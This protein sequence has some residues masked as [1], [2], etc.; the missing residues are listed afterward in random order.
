M[1]ILNVEKDKETGKLTSVAET[2]ISPKDVLKGQYVISSYTP[3]NEEKAMR[4]MILQHFAL[5]YTTMY[6]PR[7]EFNDMSV[8][9]RMTV[10]EMAFNTYQPNDG[11][12]AWGDEINAWRSNAMRPI[13]RNK[14]VSIA[15]HATARLIFPKCFAYNE[16]SDEQRDA[17]QVMEDLMEW[18]ADKSNYQQNALYRVI[19]ALTDPASIGYTEYCET[20]R[21]VKR[22]NPDGTYREEVMLDETLSGF[23]NTVVPVDELF[24]ENFY[25]QD[26]QKQGWLVWRRVIGYGLAESKYKNKSGVLSGVRHEHASVRR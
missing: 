2:K 20:Y 14:C 15:A 19:T 17:A 24:I 21:K 25:E 7:V 9:Q 26:V 6:T 23:Q 10:D 8:I 22:P 18:A 5:G 3:S 4:S 13:V 11:E 16:A 12:G 1:S